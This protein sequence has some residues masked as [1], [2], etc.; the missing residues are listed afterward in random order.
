MRQLLKVFFALVVAA[1]PSAAR[2]QAPWSI[3][4]RSN[5]I[6]G[7]IPACERNPNVPVAERPQCGVFCNCMANESEKVLSSDELKEIASAAGSGQ[8]N[9]K[10]DRLRALGPICNQQVFGRGP[11]PSEPAPP[12]A[13]SPP[14]PVATKPGPEL[15]Q[16]TVK[17]V[18][19]GLYDDRVGPRGAGPS[20]KPD[21]R[22]VLTIDVGKLSS[23]DLTHIS[24]QAIDANSRPIGPVWHTR[25]QARSL[26]LVVTG[27][28]W[29]NTRH[30]NALATLE[31]PDVDLILFADDAPE[32]TAINAFIVE[33]GFAD[34][35]LA[36]QLAKAR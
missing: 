23:R 34:G 17:L 29:L 7:C 33:V 10:I 20:G 4:E 1:L 15:P 26:L 27:N 25:D 2:A 11:P 22:F 16:G 31:G 18:Y 8:Q 35:S 36:R 24:L 21:G 5:F 12:V 28:Q 14:P 19:F 32:P 13:A 3:T 6:R 30:V 9:D